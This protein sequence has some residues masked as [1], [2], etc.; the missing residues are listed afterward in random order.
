MFCAFKDGTTSVMLTVNHIRAICKS[1]GCGIVDDCTCTRNPCVSTRTS[2]Y[3]PMIINFCR[4]MTTTFIRKIRSLSNA[5][6]GMYEFCSMSAQ[7]LWYPTSCNQNLTLFF[8]T[9]LKPKDRSEMNVTVKP[10]SIMV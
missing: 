5:A 10:L 8:Y 6:I 2:Q 7:G 9:S 3:N 1:F 4:A